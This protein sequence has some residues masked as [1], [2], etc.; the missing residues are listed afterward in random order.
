MNSASGA[1]RTDSKAKNSWKEISLFGQETEERQL[2]EC[3][4]TV[5]TMQQQYC[6]LTKHPQGN[7]GAEIKATVHFLSYHRFKIDST[8]G[9]K[10]IS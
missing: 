2:V 5:Q 6:T 3:I 1:H 4:T 7:S 8:L 10:L 9:V